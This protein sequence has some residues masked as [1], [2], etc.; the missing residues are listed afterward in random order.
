M[1]MLTIWHI[2]PILMLGRARYGKAHMKKFT[3]EFYE[4]TNGETPVEDFLNSLDKKMRS[5]MLMI[6]TVLGEKGNQ[7]RE[8]YSKYLEDG[9][10]E[11]RGKVGSDISRVLY[12]FYYGGK[13]VLT[14]GFIKK[15]QKTPPDEIRKAKAYREDYMERFGE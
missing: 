8:P 11:V 12:F 1:R 15:T 5:K 9:I 6:L 13:I 10:F 2:C 3:V 14:N 7:M 4:K